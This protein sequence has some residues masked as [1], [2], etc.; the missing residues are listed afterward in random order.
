[1][2]PARH[3]EPQQLSRWYTEGALGRV[4]LDVYLP[5]VDEG[6]LQILD[7]CVTLASLD[8]DI[9]DATKLMK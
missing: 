3:E 2:A 4:E 9:V 1:L 8:D 7:E 5:Q 6:F